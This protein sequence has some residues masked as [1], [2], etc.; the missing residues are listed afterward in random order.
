MVVGID[1]YDNMKQFRCFRHPLSLLQ[2]HGIMKK[3]NNE[4]MIHSKG[5][6]ELITSW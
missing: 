6:I 1:Q 5:K 3:W 2:I 4:I